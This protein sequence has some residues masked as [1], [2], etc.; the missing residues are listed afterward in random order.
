MSRRGILIARLNGLLIYR[1]QLLLCK[2]VIK[3]HSDEI[4]KAMKS[5]G[6][7]FAD[8]AK[9]TKNFGKVLRKKTRRMMRKS[10]RRRK[11]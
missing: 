11:I 4:I 2:E 10:K 6:Y 1:L 9:S 7:V 8:A 5:M 3:E